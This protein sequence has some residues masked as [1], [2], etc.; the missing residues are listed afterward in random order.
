[1]AVTTTAVANNQS[2]SAGFKEA[3]YSGAKFVVD[4]ASSN[5]VMNTKPVPNIFQNLMRSSVDVMQRSVD[6]FQDVSTTVFQKARETIRSSRESV[7]KR[8]GGAS[9]R[10]KRTGIVGSVA[11]F[12][13]TGVAGMEQATD[14]GL[15]MANI[16]TSKIRSELDGTDGNKEVLKILVKYV[17]SRIGMSTRGSAVQFVDDIGT[18][19]TFMAEDDDV[20][21]SISTI[22]E[23]LMENPKVSVAMIRMTLTVLES[24]PSTSCLLDQMP[25]AA[26]DLRMLFDVFVGSNGQQMMKTVAGLLKDITTGPDTK[27][28]LQSLLSM[29]SMF[30]SDTPAKPGAKPEKPTSLVNSL[31]G[32]FTG[33][34]EVEDD[35]EETKKIIKKHRGSEETVVRNKPNIIQQTPISQEDDDWFNNNDYKGTTS[36]SLPIKPSQ[37]MDKFDASEISFNKKTQSENVNID[38]TKSKATIV[39][40]S[41][42][43]GVVEKKNKSRS[44]VAKT[45]KPK[46]NPVPRQDDNLFGDNVSLD[47]DVQ[48]NQ[49]LSKKT[50]PSSV[51]PKL[52]KRSDESYNSEISINK[53]TRSGNAKIAETTSKTASASVV[54]ENKN[55]P[56][57]SPITDTP[58]LAET[59]DVMR[60][61]NDLF[62]TGGDSSPLDNKPKPSSP[63]TLRRPKQVPKQVDN[64][65]ADGNSLEYETGNVNI[66]ES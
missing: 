29:M 47:N 33:D 53:E 32:F 15:V 5:T 17:A 48:P 35:H 54:V 50:K 61:S 64:T 14:L 43:S 57:S 6:T 49:S 3:N 4:N 62:N 9:G 30:R 66:A 22:M 44:S 1:M 12:I 65:F 58:D 56:Q 2:S 21:R 27:A 7:E 42:N 24:S 8:S 38:D 39:T 46:A 40:N 20:T 45:S 16:G 36:K 37:Q 13:D 31:S 63:K 19:S 11:N 10:R 25:L 23:K 26:A 51:K 52:S 28:F 18:I 41:D 59:P 34:G 60:L 55:K